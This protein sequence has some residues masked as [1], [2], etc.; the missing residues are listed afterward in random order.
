M[1]H[2]SISQ[3]QAGAVALG[4]DISIMDG[5][6]KRHEGRLDRTQGKNLGST[7]GCKRNSAVST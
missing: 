7:V 2:R 4:Q 3:G 6:G 1:V 5:E